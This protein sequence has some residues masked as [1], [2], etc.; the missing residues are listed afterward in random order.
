MAL[1]GRYYIALLHSS[2]PG[3]GISSG[4][5]SVDVERQMQER[6]KN[7]A[8]RL[9]NETVAGGLMGVYLEPGYP[10]YFINEQMLRYLGYTYDEFMEA[11][12]G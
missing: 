12:G 1:E 7:E 10:L 6:V 11:T 4:H 5:Y 3:D 2:V 8:F 9:L